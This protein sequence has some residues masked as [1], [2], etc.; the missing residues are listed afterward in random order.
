MELFRK[1]FLDGDWQIAFR[2]KHN[3]IFDYNSSF[4]SVK[5]TKQYWFADPMIVSEGEDTFLFC[6]AYDRKEE[7]G[8]IGYFKLKNDVFSEFKVVISEKYHLSYPCVFKYSNQYYMIPESGE[9]NTLDLYRSI[10]FP[11]QWE[12]CGTLL[13][14]ERL[15][16]STIFYYDNKYYLYSY[17]EGSS[18]QAR[19]Y[20][21]DIE[22]R[23]L[24]L[25][26]NIDYEFNEGRGAGYVFK[27]ND[28]WIRPVQ[29][30]KE[31]YGKTV[32]FREVSLEKDEREKIVSKINVN[33]VKIDCNN[34]VDRIHT[35]SC[36]DNYEV[37]DFCKMK[38]SLFKRIKILRRKIKTENR[39]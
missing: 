26:K 5:N 39:K 23:K 22:K 9:N 37:I 3:N 16:D 13:E 27:Y 34:I 4:F 7:K 35:Y 15:V 33:S 11:D 8:A 36:N 10:Q 20:D 1:M 6:E 29:D 24:R 19:I 30:C 18:Y 38:F 31:I 17:L 28:K 12:K 14:G 25:V 32:L 2:K 21:F